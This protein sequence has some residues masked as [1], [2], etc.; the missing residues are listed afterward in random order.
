MD[1]RTFAFDDA[2][3][4]SSVIHGDALTELS[5]LEDNSF[6]LVV[7]SPPYNIG[8]EYERGQ[9]RTLDQYVKW[10][11]PIVKQ[12]CK[13]V[14]EDGSICWQVGN[15]INNGQVFPLDLFFYQMFIEQG[16]QL[17]NRIIWHFNFGLHANQR[18]SGRYET[19]LWF[20]KSDT[21][22]FHLDPVRVP[23]L[24]PG[25]RH[26]S[27]RPEKASEPSGNP[28]GKNPSDFWEFS[29]EDAFIQNPVWN[30]P[31]VKAKHPEKTTHPC[32]FPSE[33]AERCVLALT[34]H[35]DKVLDPFVGAG[36]SVI[37]A[38]KHGRIGVGIDQSDQYVRIARDRVAKYELGE[39]ELR[40]AGKSV[41]KPKAGEK[42]A[43]FPTEWLEQAP[44]SGG[45]I[46]GQSEAEEKDS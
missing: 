7:T 17:R 20:S 32:Q 38:I 33:L 11:Q 21:Y 40:P 44:L 15:Y 13:K 22:K 46:E 35:G 4:L 39:L 28:L 41:R 37:A 14:R 34:D 42:V 25:K 10:L 3:R 30:I 31:N 2:Q 16:F 45:D 27:K 18:F 8:K 6:Q 36:T 26:G 29:P 24:Y 19:L 23:Q 1:Q 5:K 43:Q 9:R 12:V